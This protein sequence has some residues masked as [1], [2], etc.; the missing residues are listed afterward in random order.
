[1]VCFVGP[2]NVGKTTVVSKVIAHLTEQG[3][4]V[5]ALKHASHSFQ[6]DRAGKD[7]HHFRR[8]G[9][10]AIGIASKT[11]RALITTTDK[12]ATLVELAASLPAG[13]D[14]II[15]EGYKSEGAPKVEVHRGNGPLLTGLEGLIAVV[16]DSEP[17][18]VTVPKFGHDGIADLCAFLREHTGR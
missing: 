6:M 4:K 5:G 17:D 18:G 14:V 10:Y 8:S 7:T 1:M 13:L 15:V 12:P 11:E 3:L 9:A 16:T 2:S